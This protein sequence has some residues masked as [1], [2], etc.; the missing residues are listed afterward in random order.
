MSCVF[1]QNQTCHIFRMLCFDQTRNK[2]CYSTIIMSPEFSFPCI[3]VISPFCLHSR[4]NSYINMTHSPVIR[5]V[6]CV[7]T[8]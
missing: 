6:K 5:F 8:F 4:C 2:S 1:N 3:V 7:L